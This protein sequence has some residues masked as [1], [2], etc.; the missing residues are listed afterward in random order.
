MKNLQTYKDQLDNFTSPLFDRINSLKAVECPAVVSD[1]LTAERKLQKA[2]EIIAETSDTL[3]ESEIKQNLIE[4]QNLANS[5]LELI[6]RE[7]ETREALRKRVE[8]FNNLSEEEKEKRRESAQAI[9]ALDDIDHPELPE[10]TT[11]QLNKLDDAKREFNA[12]LLY[13]SPSPR[14]RT[15]SRMPSSA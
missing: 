8:E 11:E 6:T 15:R 12:C 5:A 4:C 3:P 14:D 2:S 10:L 7:E 13:T 1:H 9:A